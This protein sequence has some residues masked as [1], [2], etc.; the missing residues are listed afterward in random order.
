MTTL[1]VLSRNTG[2]LRKYLVLT[3]FAAI[4]ITSLPFAASAQSSH[5]TPTSKVS[6]A[7]SERMRSLSSSTTVPIIFKSNGP[8]GVNLTALLNRSNVRV[9]GQFATFEM[10]A[11]DLPVATVAELASMPEVSVVDFDS[12]V[13]VLGHLTSTTGAE[14]VRTSLGP[15]TALDGAGVGIAV[16]DSGVYS[17]HK[18]F[19]KSSGNGSRVV[20]SKDFTGENRTDDPYGHGTHVA[21]IAAG[22]YSLYS[23]SYAGPRPFRPRR[24]RG[25][26]A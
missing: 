11:L 23:G 18:A 12:P 5:A 6:P 8:A 25:H 13:R 16:V 2:C 15:T 1:T 19:L 21:A 3:L 4:S 14:Q 17:D 20:Y 9:K 22:G 24:S 10:T 7:L 26:A